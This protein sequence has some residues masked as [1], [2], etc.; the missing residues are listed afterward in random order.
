MKLKLANLAPLKEG[1]M[2]ARDLAD[3][4][5]LQQ[6]KA[7]YDE[8]LRDMEQEAEPEGGP[9]ADQYVDQ[10]HDIEQAMQ[11]KSPFEKDSVGGMTYDQAIGRSKVAADRASFERSSKFK[12]AGERSGFDMRGLKEQLG[13]RMKNSRPTGPSDDSSSKDIEFDNAQAMDRL[14]QDDKDKLGK[15]N[16]MMDK[17]RGDSLEKDLEKKIEDKFDERGSVSEREAGVYRLKFSYMRREFEDEKWDE[18]LE[19][20]ESEGYFIDKNKTSNSYEANYDREEPAESIPTIYF[21][22]QEQDFLKEQ[23]QIRAGI[24]K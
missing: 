10:M 1:S 12:K 8:L 23:L 5:S 3:R 18:I 7:M 11:I 2:Q 9:I 6:L 13:P 17:E 14:T 21:S 24:I 19:Y 22:T 4:N 16:Q 15:I 20:L